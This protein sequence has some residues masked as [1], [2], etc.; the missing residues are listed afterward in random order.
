MQRDF[1][2]FVLLILHFQLDIVS[3]NIILSISLRIFE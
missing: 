3:M 2:E 1:N